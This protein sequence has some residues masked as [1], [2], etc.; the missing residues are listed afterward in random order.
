VV[1]TSAE[2]EFVCKCSCTKGP[3]HDDP[4]CGPVPGTAWSDINGP[5][6]AR[7]YNRTGPWAEDAARGTVPVRPVARASPAR[8]RGRPGGGPA[9]QRLGRLYI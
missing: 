5:R 9:C 2:G 8:G 7:P 1:A 3:R 6:A 4:V